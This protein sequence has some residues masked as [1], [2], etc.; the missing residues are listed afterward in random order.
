MEDGEDQEAQKTVQSL[1]FQSFSQKNKKKFKS[2]GRKGK[3]PLSKLSGDLLSREQR[4]EFK[5]AIDLAKKKIPKEEWDKKTPLEKIEHTLNV[6]QTI[7]AIDQKRR[8]V[9]VNLARAREKED[10]EKARIASA[11]NPWMDN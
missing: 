8:Q 9:I 4:E 5:K 3:S 2:K 11:L 6:R 7:Q 10:F 1:T